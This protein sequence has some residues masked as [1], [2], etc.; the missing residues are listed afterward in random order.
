MN[1]E[2]N[3]FN[4]REEL[5][6]ALLDPPCVP[7]LGNFLTEVA[8]THAFQAVSEKCQVATV[9]A[10][11]KE[12]SEQKAW[13]QEL[14]CQKDSIGNN[15]ATVVNLPSEG[16]QQ[17]QQQR[18][19]SQLSLKKSNFES[20]SNEPAGGLLPDP[21]T[22]YTINGRDHSRTD[23]DDSGV[24]LSSSKRYSNYSEDL[25][26]PR[27]ESCLS[28]PDEE[29]N[30][31]GVANIQA[32]YLKATKSLPTDYC[33]LRECECR[34]WKYQISCVQYNYVK[35][36]LIYRYLANSPFNTEE[37]SYKLSLRREAPKA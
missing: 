4:Y 6:T 16:I 20:F 34:F 17:Q 36:P 14:E 10:T 3:F 28:S 8:H 2:N 22:V 26:S 12:N 30:G 18:R 7:F 19:P 33:S 9:L 27:D 29:Y 13:K 15:M 31:R 35:R 21:Q 25:E 37:D 11:N 32:R 1:E 23:S 5:S 24:V